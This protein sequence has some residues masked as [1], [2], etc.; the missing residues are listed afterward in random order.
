MRSKVIAKEKRIVAA[1]VETC[2]SVSH[3]PPTQC[4]AIQVLRGSTDLHYGH[5]K[6]VV[7]LSDTKLLLNRCYMN[8]G[9]NWDLRIELHWSEF[10]P[11]AS[12]SVF[13]FRLW[14]VSFSCAAS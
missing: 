4:N 14:L 9:W 3:S 7:K 8:P 12:N 5:M 6:I 11:G 2:H 1:R 13:I 10:D